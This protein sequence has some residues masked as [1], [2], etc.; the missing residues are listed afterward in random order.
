MNQVKT[1]TRASRFLARRI[2]AFSAI[3]PKNDCLEHVSDG[4]SLLALEVVEHAAQL[5]YA[6]AAHGHVGSHFTQAP[7]SA[8][9]SLALG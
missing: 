3:E 9:W 5:L 8:A 1:N 2:N 4:F 7:L 6:R